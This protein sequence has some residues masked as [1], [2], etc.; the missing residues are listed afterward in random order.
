MMETMEFE[1]LALVR[2]VLV[3]C[4][5]LLG[6]F[7]GIKA[8]DRWN[9]WVGWMAGLAICIALG[10]FL[11]PVIELLEARMCQIEPLMEDCY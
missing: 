6:L 2:I 10:A 4:P 11:F 7:G 3:C 1:A 5:F 9:A 8:S